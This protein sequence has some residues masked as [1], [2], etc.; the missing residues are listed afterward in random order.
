[1]NLAENLERTARA[2]G[3]SAAVTV[4]DRVATFAELDRDSRGVAGL[5]A[6]RGVR[7]GDRVGVALPNVPEFAA[8]YYAVLRLGAVVV[9]LNPLMEERV[10]VDHL[11]DSGART[12]LA[13]ET[14]SGAAVPAARELGTD[15]LVLGPG[16]LPGLVAG[17]P[18]LDRVEPRA[19]GDAAV[20]LYTSGTTGRPRGVELT[21][22]NLVRN[23]EVVVN[24]VLQLTSED[25][26]FGGL[27]LFHSFGQT[28]G[29]NAAVR[30][31]ACLSLLPRFDADAA[32]R[33]LQDQRVTV[34]QGVPPMYAAMLRSPHRGDY[35]LS[36]LRVGVS[37]CA[38]MPVGVLLGFEEAFDS[39]VLE[40]YGL[41]EASPVVSFNR[42]DRRRVGSVGLPVKGVELRVVD[43]EGAEVVDGEPGELLVRGHNVMK[44]YWGR[45]EDTAA[46]LVDGWLRTG[47]VGLRDDDGFFYVLGRTTELID[48]G[49]F[50][51]Y[52]REVEEI[53]LEHPDVSEA[54]VVGLPDT[55]LGEEVGAVVTLRPLAT[56]TGEEL[57]DFV[58]GRVAAHKYPRTVDIV[59]EIPKTATGKIL[60]RAIRLENRA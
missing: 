44:G 45:P 47:D 43:D 59:D 58:K 14:A 57:R 49:G 22:G 18:A 29:L 4:G 30:A 31:G 2:R 60:K 42:R 10:V 9:P 20:I 27:S 21:H 7:P 51:V 36:R 23:C 28:A 55:T 39:L 6:Q 3:R 25:V 13:W 24:D 12:L 38:P 53:L 26:V 52:P 16:G 56:A 32:L 19:A 17:A 34:M 50:T 41:S 54:A 48:R 37:G 11:Q 35:D 5:L 8:V 1:V 40:G 15:V 33:T 46:V